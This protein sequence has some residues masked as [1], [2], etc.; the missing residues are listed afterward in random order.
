MIASCRKILKL[1]GGVDRLIQGHGPKL[2]RLYP[3][4]DVNSIELLA[5]HEEPQPFDAAELKRTDDF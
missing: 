1:A 4:H 2:R 3:T 5:L